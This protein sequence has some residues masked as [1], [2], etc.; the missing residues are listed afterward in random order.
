MLYLLILLLYFHYTLLPVRMG[1]IRDA[2][3][4]NYIKDKLC[5][6]V[7]KLFPS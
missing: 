7:M 6:V 1:H 2:E 5:G 4:R 3:G